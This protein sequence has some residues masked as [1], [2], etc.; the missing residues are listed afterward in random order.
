MSAHAELLRSDERVDTTVAADTL[1]AALMQTTTD[2]MALL[3]RETQVLHSG[4]MDQLSSLQLRKAA[5]NAML[6]RDIAQFRGNVVF[7]RE[8]VPVRLAALK[9]H[10]QLFQRTLDTN[11][12]ILSAMRAVSD[13]LLKAIAS[14][15]SAADAGPETYGKNASALNPQPR[16]P[17]AISVNRS[18]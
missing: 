8:A 10:F 12:A 16:R 2:L 15:A 4:K 17:S 18:L 5:L 9:E 11:Q 6:M 14:R 3:D 1:C 13:A 7:M